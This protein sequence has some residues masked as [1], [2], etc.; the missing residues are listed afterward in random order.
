MMHFYCWQSLTPVRAQNF[1]RNLKRIFHWGEGQSLANHRPA[2]SARRQ[3]FYAHILKS[4]QKKKVKN[5]NTRTAG[6]IG[7]NLKWTAA[8]PMGRGVKKEENVQGPSNLGPMPK[9][10][11]VPQALAHPS[12]APSPLLFIFQAQLNPNE[13]SRS[14]ASARKCPRDLK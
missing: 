2:K 11:P 5:T 1:E 12:A 14:L 10:V 8:I 13:K 6:K 3:H 7:K 4:S 9:L